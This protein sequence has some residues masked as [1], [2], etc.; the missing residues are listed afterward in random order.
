MRRRLAVATGTMAVIALSSVSLAQTGGSPILGWSHAF[1]NGAGF[2]RVTPRHV[3]LGGD[4]T[5]NVTGC[6]G[7]AGVP[8]RRSAWARA[9]V[10]ASL[11]PT[12]TTAASRYMRSTSAGATVAR[13]IE[14]CR[15]TSSQDHTGDGP[16]ARNGTSAPAN[17]QDH[18]H[19]QLVTMDCRQGARPMPGGPRVEAIV[20][21]A[22]SS[23][24]PWWARNSSGTGRERLRRRMEGGRRGAIA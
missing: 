23:A 8:E 2:G 19:Y 15:S 20:S 16:S 5:G 4:P 11:W 18:R 21:A 12:G 22:G 14:S 1:P 9:G 3:Y 10:L 6:A 24:P 7:V 17:P 13:R